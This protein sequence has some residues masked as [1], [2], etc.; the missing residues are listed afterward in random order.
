M[1]T[2]D[3]AGIAFT[4]A[5]SG[6]PLNATY[7]AGDVKLTLADGTAANLNQGAY[8]HHIL[9]IDVSKKSSPLSF[10]IG[11]NSTRD[12][13][14]MSVFLGTG[15]DNSGGWMFTDP[16]GEFNSGFYVGGADRMMMVGEIVSY[17]NE[18]REVFVEAEVEWE[19]GRREGMLDTKVA[20]ISATGCGS[21]S[22]EAPG[23]APNTSSS[24]SSSPSSSSSSSSSSSPEA[25]AHAGTGT[26]AA[27]T[28][29]HASASGHAAVDA[30]PAPQTTAFNY[31]GVDYRLAFDGLV[32]QQR[33]HL[34][35]GGARM[36]AYLNGSPICT[37]SATYGGELGTLVDASTGEKMWE[38]II[39][40]ENCL[41]PVE[42]KKGD[43]LRLVAEYDPG[44]H[45]LR[46]EEHGGMAEEMGIV[47]WYF[48]T[49]PEGVGE[50]YVWPRLKAEQTTQVGEA[51]M[52][53][54]K[55]KGC[56][57]RKRQAV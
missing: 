40:M 53:K 45:P 43:V 28:D 20:T 37:S 31:T 48:V 17:A 32:L 1:P 25:G 10:C 7:L 44:S 55:G 9:L 39:G 18:T 54:G 13:A 38:T 36:L 16:L 12:V 50:G 21:V 29:T 14:P 8:L 51:K 4:R 11:A 34:H 2:M 41:E 52:D 46:V 22:F 27:E 5:I 3:P 33:G 57:K 19:E 47:S 42:V 30:P 15:N 35:D 26:A 6:L 56:K 49:R 23:A 24:S